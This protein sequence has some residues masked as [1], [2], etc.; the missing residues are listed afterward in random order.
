MFLDISGRVYSCGNNRYGQ[1]GLGLIDPTHLVHITP[2]LVPGFTDC[3][4][5]VACG[6]YHTLVMS[7]S[8]L[9]YSCGENGAGQLGYGTRN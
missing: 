1:L 3:S 4:K 2:T 9:V 7:H 5:Q 6:D 8:G